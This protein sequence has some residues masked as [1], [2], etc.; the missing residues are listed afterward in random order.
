MLKFITILFLLILHQANS[1]AGYVIIDG[2]KINVNKPLEEKKYKLIPL[3]GMSFDVV[4]SVCSRW[5]ADDGLLKYERKKAAVLVYDFPSTI[6]KIE[7]FITNNYQEHA[8]KNIRI[9]VL[10]DN[11]GRDREVDWK[12]NFSREN[13][14]YITVKGGRHNIPI[15]TEVNIP[16]STIMNSSQYRKQ[17]I[18]VKEGY[19]AKLWV[20]ESSVTP[21]WLDDLVKYNI[22]QYSDGRRSVNIIGPAEDFI[23]VDVGSALMVKAR[24]VGG[25]R[26]EV[27]LYPE[28]SYKNKNGAQESIEVYSIA[29]KVTVRPG[30]RVNIGGA[31]SNNLDTYKNLF[32]KQ[33][34][35]RVEQGSVMNMYLRATIE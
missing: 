20:G 14:G 17:E 8:E 23:F 33:L 2:E 6:S 15:G 26:I 35:K 31:I 3:R 28:I 24:I 5:L 1:F 7:K 32:G 12:N 25:N 11:I 19:P 34:Y 10:F 4:N 18:L 30:A 29:T 9:E 16:T 13:R 27:E 22:T 21:Q